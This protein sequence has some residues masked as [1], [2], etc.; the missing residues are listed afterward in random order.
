MVPQR[1]CR[2]P[3]YQS[4]QYMLTQFDQVSSLRG[5]SVMRRIRNSPLFASGSTPSALR[6]LAEFKVHMARN[7]AHTT[8]SGWTYTSGSISPAN[9]ST[10]LAVTRECGK[11][12]CS[13]V[14][15]QRLTSGCTRQD[16]AAA[17]WGAQLCMYHQGQTGYQQVTEIASCRA[18]EA[19]SSMNS[20]VVDTTGWP[21]KVQYTRMQVT[22]KSIAQVSKR[23]FRALSGNK[24][25]VSRP[26]RHDVRESARRQ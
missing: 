16:A 1:E 23:I 25:P 4:Q 8:V 20:Q 5:S 15:E 2:P 19:E 24:P 26:R 10:R 6:R 21:A 3:R 12:V 22:V 7:A 9:T 17:M 18:A 13:N 11:E 14:T